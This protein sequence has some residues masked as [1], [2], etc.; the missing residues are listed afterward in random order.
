[1]FLSNKAS[2]NRDWSDDQNVLPYDRFEL[3]Y[4]I[5]D[6][7]DLIKLRSNHRRN[8]VYV[9]PLKM[10]HETVRNLFLDMLKRANHL[11][12]HPEFYNT[13]TNACTT[14]I[15]RHI[16]HVTPNQIPLLSISV[17]LPKFSDRLAYDLGFLDT[18]LPFK[19]ARE[20][21]HIND[22]AIKFADAAD[23]SV[24]IRE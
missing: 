11:R 16:N 14:N 23:F 17:L 15:V 24:K 9:Y 13:I 2:N 8:P 20:K 10:S 4:V 6:E 12:T 7:R 19:K 3:M 5:A 22:R 21:Y 18:D 1:M